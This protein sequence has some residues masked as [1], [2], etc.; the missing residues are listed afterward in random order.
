MRPIG[1]STGAVAKGD[2]SS[3]LENLRPY[4]LQAVELSAI[5]LPELEVLVRSLSQLDLTG[6]DF[7]SFHAPS[8][9]EPAEEPWVIEQ[10]AKVAH[11]GIAVVVHPDVIL[12]PS[13]WCQFGQVLLL[14]NMD[15]RKPVGRTARDLEEL[16]AGF[17]DARFC[18]D[19]AHAR[20]VDPTMIEARLILERFAGRLAEVHISELNTRSQHDPISAYAISDYQSVAALIPEN[21][22]II[23]ETLIDQGQ[24]DIPTEIN[25][26]R[27]AL[28]S[29]LIEQNWGTALGHSR[30]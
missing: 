30:G 24:S 25:R 23:L 3:A 2:F 1:F 7:V 10:L 21:V 22:P 28:D 11:Q 6:Y 9:F 19:I 29:S 4:H 26:A 16:F 17:P 5:R 18:F 27:R 8:K 14:E 20:Q 13:P 15:K 12:D